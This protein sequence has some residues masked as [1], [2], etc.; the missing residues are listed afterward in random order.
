MHS[1]HDRHSKV[2]L[3]QKRAFNVILGMKQLPLEERLNFEKSEARED[4]V[5]QNHQIKH[6]QNHHSPNPATPGVKASW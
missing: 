6:M 3:V 2:Q 4:E 5:L 1:A